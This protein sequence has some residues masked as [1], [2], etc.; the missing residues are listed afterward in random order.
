M[1]AVTTRFDSTKHDMRN[2]RNTASPVSIGAKKVVHMLSSIGLIRTRMESGVHDF[3]GLPKL[4]SHR[5]NMTLLVRRDEA[6]RIFEPGGGNKESSGIT[7][8]RQ[9]LKMCEQEECRAIAVYLPHQDLVR[10]LQLSSPGI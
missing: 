10:R 2:G 6:F 9:H 1:P 8:V 7:H 4:R 5:L 3:L